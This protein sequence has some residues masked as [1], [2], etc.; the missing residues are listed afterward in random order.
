MPRRV[1]DSDGT[2]RA[3][4]G[5]PLGGWWKPAFA[6]AHG[7]GRLD[8]GQVAVRRRPNPDGLQALVAGD[9]V[10]VPAGRE[11]AGSIRANRSGPRCWCSSTGSSTGVLTCSHR[12][13]RGVDAVWL[14]WL[15]DR[16]PASGARV[17]TLVRTRG[18]V[19]GAEAAGN[20]AGDGLVSHG[21][22]GSW[23][24][25]QEV[26]WLSDPAMFSPCKPRSLRLREFYPADLATAHPH[27]RPGGRG[28]R[29]LK[30]NLGFEEYDGPSL[31]TASCTS[32]RAG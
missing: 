17:V 15:R 23:R 12:R 6:S 26:V 8:R 14:A 19:G 5:K 16:G 20:G 25:R 9:R 11:R 13:S 32:P 3:L 28:T 31:E 30:Y 29:Y 2:F 21:R 7:P 1:R 18:G 10:L 24:A 27:L 22:R 4:S